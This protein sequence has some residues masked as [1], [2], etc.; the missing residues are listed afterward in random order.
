[1]SHASILQGFNSTLT[2]P[3][4]ALGRGGSQIREMEPKLH[5]ALREPLTRLSDDP[6]TTIVVL[7]GSDRNVLDEV[8]TLLVL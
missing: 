5:P 3:I 4:G 1:M 8:L 6:K 2:E 7:S